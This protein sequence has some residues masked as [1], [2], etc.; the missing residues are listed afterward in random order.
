ML[1]AKV[2]FCR[3]FECRKLIVRYRPEHVS[4]DPIACIFEALADG[5]D[6]LPIA[7][8]LSCFQGCGNVIGSYADDFQHS[9]QSKPPPSI[10][11]EFC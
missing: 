7:I 4:L 3:C 5:G 8:L 2:A 11:G 6:G 9:L 10:A 1:F